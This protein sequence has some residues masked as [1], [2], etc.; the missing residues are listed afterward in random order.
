MD[1]IRKYDIEGSLDKGL[2]D[3]IRKKERLI[4]NIRENGCLM[5][6][7]IDNEG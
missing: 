3:G 5:D 6:G 4:D 7:I 1:G 2:M